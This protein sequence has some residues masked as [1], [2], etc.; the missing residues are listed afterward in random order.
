MSRISFPAA[1]ASTTNLPAIAPAAL[2]MTTFPGTIV[3]CAPG[4]TPA[5][6]GFSAGEAWTQLYRFAY[7][8]AQ[9]ALE[10]SRFQMRLSPCW[11]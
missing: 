1:S 6:G 7:Q 10:P 8:Q 4:F 3:A 11:N 9:A 5:A 2:A